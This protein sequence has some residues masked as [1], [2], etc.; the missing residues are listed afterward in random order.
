MTEVM[1]RI[2][3]AARGL[4]YLL[5]GA[6]AFLAAMSAKAHPTGS[7]GALQ[8]LLDEPFGKG[9]L[10]AAA[11]G[12]AAFAAWRL[13][14]AIFDTDR[15]G[16]SLKGIVVRSARV[17]SGLIYAGSAF[18]ALSLVFG[19]GTGEDHEAHRDWTVWL[20]D[21]PYGPWLLGLVG[22][23][24]IGAGCAFIHKGWRMTFR[25]RLSL[26]DRVERWV[27]PMGRVGFLARGL[28]F[29]L[30]GLL[31][32]L[33][34]VHGNSFEGQGLGGALRALERQPHGWLL[35]AATSLGL[36]AYGAFGLVEAAFR[37]I[38]APD[39]GAAAGNAVGEARGGD[40]AGMRMPP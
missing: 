16:R 32:I 29:G 9:L 20:L 2:G 13:T 1:A 24:V 6:L 7:R 3:Y 5:V 26:T 11:L 8:G 30:A 40:G 4:I 36:A 19:W 34:A 33:G 18:F 12:L 28:V 10:T 17:V 38:D 25:T 31:L 22:A 15:L 21:V 27:V 37:R 14:D 35:L 23:I 39:L